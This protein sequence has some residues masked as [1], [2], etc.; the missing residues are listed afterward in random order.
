[1]ASKLIYFTQKKPKQPKNEKVQPK[2]SG[3]KEKTW[4]LVEWLE[5]LSPGGKL[6]IKIPP[7]NKACQK[8]YQNQ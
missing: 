6:D 7:K 4:S 3:T 5:S 8:T 2:G 1:M